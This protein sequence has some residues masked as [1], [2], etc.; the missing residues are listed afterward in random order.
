[1][2]AALSRPFLQL[3]EAS[4]AQ[5]CA[6]P[7]NH[8]SSCNFIKLHIFKSKTNKKLL[9]PQHLLSYTPVSSKTMFSQ[10]WSLSELFEEHGKN[11]GAEVHPIFIVVHV[12]T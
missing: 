11:T 7:T 9:P 10:L 3:T 2:A 8:S 6:L 4:G 12:N 5:Q 1:M